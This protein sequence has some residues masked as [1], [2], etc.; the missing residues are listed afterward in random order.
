M[1]V[2]R[3][4][5]KLLKKSPGPPSGQSDALVPTLGN[6][7]ANLIRLANS[8]IVLC[9]NDVSLLPILIPGKNFPHFVSAFRERL[10]G[11]LGR[12]GLP[13]DRISVEQAAMEIVQVQPTNNRSVLGSMN[14]LVRHLKWRM[15]THFD[16]REA[17]QLEDMLSEIPMGSL[18]YEYPIEVAAAAFGLDWTA[19][20]GDVS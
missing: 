2:L 10:A 17:N 1:L 12:I 19:S 4:T 6:W 20:R 8:P 9:V 14:D 18:K 16:F 11:R 7:H 5:Q 15:G 13:H 3:C